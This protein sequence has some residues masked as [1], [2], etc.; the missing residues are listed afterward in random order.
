MEPVLAADGGSA[1][2]PSHG[3][4]SRHT[5]RAPGAADAGAPLTPREPCPA[6]PVR[7]VSVRALTADPLPGGDGAIEPIREMPGPA[8][9]G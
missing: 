7:E 8:L 1:R 9:V 5:T 2:A 4:G 3:R 6:G